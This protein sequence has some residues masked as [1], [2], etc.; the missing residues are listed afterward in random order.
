[1]RA[2]HEHDGPSGQNCAGQGRDD[3]AEI[4]DREE[5]RQ[6]IE[7]AAKA[8]ACVMRS[9]ERLHRHLIGAVG[10]GIGADLCEIQ[11]RELHAGGLR[12]MKAHA[13]NAQPLGRASLFQHGT[14]GVEAH[15]AVAARVWLEAKGA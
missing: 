7:E 13:V 4:L 5:I 11:R 14:N 3:L 8:P 9:R 1:M 2:H 6:A 12:V 10:D 15:G